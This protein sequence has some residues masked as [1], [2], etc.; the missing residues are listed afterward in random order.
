M[1]TAEGPPGVTSQQQ[2]RDLLERKAKAIALRPAI[3]QATARTTIRLK[4]GLECEVEEGAW[5]LTVGMSEKSGGTNAGPN[6]GVL[7][8]AALGSCLAL[9]YAMWA[10]RLG[11]PIDALDVE[12]QADYDS[13]G[14]LGVSDVVPPGY[15][16]VRYRVTVI[17]P[18]SDAEVRRVIDTAD[19]YSPFKDVFARAH[20][21]RRELVIAASD[22]SS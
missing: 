13:R 7:G 4:P 22:P 10:A 18:A 2:L 8:R 11:V 1:T 5:K 9:A 15:L 20:E 21:L 12:V 16:Q 17:S 6:P 19:K 3:G 14:E